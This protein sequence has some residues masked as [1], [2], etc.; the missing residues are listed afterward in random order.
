[1]STTQ[2]EPTPGAPSNRGRHYAGWL[3]G[4]AGTWRQVVDAADAAACYRRLLAHVRQL[5]KT[6]PATA[7]LPA[8]VHP[9]DQARRAA[10]LLRQPADPTERE[11]GKQ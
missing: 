5:P 9:E 7:V 3:K 2:Q 1:V 11:G 6:P 4:P 8:G 10:L